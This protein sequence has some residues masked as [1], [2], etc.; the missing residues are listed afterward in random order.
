MGYSLGQ[1]FYVTISSRP[2]CGLNT[3]IL[4][5]V[6]INFL[7]LVTK[8]KICFCSVIGLGHIHCWIISDDVMSLVMEISNC[9]RAL[10]DYKIKR[11]LKGL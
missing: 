3:V 11:P 9:L 8:I 10:R 2:H 5:L 7:L 6:I 4:D 1:S